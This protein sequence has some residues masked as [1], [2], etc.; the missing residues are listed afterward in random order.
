MIEAADK[1]R[2]TAVAAIFTDGQRDKKKELLGADFTGQ[3]YAGFPGGG[4]SVSAQREV[5]L[6]PVLGPTPPLSSASRACR[7]N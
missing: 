7:R 5:H 1:E 2:D 6:R 4:I 3:V